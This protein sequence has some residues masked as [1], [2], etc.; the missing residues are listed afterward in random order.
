MRFSGG[1]TGLLATLHAASAFYRIHVFG[2]TGALEMR[3]ETELLVSDLDGNSERFTYP[4]IDKE[5]AE[6]EDFADAIGA[7][8]KFVIAPEEVVNGVAAMEAVAESARTRQP[9]KIAPFG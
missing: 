2:S 5:G 7:G 1:A 3:G 4:A 8:L 9:V 6:L